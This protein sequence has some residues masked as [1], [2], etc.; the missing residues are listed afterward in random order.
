MELARWLINRGANLDLPA[1]NPMK[2]A[3]LHAASASRHL[4]IVRALLEGGANPNARQQGGFT[5]LHAA[6]QNGDA[7]IARLL[8]EKGADR[9]A[10]AENNQTALDFALLRG[11]A[12]VAAVIEG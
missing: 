4:E 7:E 11:H 1:D 8:I 12:A 5:P 2:V 3:P 6:A 9:E 10:R